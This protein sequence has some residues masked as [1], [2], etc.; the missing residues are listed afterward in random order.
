MHT[1]TPDVVAEEYIPVEEAALSLRLSPRKLKRL[2][3]Q[4]GLPLYLFGTRTQ[5]IKRVTFSSWSAAP[6]SKPRLHNGNR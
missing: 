4:R 6:L 5:R 3:V 2:L 1:Q